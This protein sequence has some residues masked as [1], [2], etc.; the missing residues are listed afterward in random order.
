[1]R[2]NSKIKL[3]IQK[4]MFEQIVQIRTLL[5]NVNQIL[6][7]LYQDR[8]KAT[9]IIEEKDKKIKELEDKIKELQK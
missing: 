3:N 5:A 4:N 7:G 6:Q 8:E 2:K 9:K 1:M